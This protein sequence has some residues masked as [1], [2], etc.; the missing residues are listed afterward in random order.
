MSKS[1][2]AG[3]KDEKGK[4]LFEKAG[5]EERWHSY[6]EKTLCKGP[7]YHSIFHI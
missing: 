1:K 3:V 6:P 2:V 7:Y 5:I 4:V